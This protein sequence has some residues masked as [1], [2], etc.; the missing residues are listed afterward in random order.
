MYI[1]KYQNPSINHEI[2][3]QTLCANTRARSWWTDRADGVTLKFSHGRENK[4]VKI[5]RSA[6]LQEVKNL[7][8]NEIRDGNI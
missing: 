4:K 7:D 6:T 5:K 1:C 2:D 8:R 3:R